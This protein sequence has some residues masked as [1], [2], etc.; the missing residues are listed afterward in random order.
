MHEPA[1]DGLLRRR[2]DGA[3]VRQGIYAPGIVRL[4]RGRLPEGAPVVDCR[5][6]P[7]TLAHEIPP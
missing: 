3:H 4:V 5:G 1:N 7:G 6:I 2:T